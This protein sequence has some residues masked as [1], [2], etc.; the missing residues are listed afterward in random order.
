MNLVAGGRVPQPYRC[1]LAACQN[2]LT[3]RRE[4]DGPHVVA[5]SVKTAHRSSPGDFRKVHVI[6]L[7][8]IAGPKERATAWRYCHA[9]ERGTAQVTHDAVW[10]LER[11]FFDVPDDRGGTPP[12]LRV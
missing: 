9:P 7:V 2:P 6:I 5:V 1:I 12:K 4:R 10:F 11:V 8:A 3:V